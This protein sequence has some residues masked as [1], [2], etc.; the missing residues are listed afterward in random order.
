[1]I[2][3]EIINNVLDKMILSASGWRGVFSACGNEEGTSSEI[4]QAHRVICASAAL[5]F[6][7][8]LQN[9]SD[10]DTFPPL[11]LVA[12]DTRPT[13]KAIADAMIPALLNAGCNVRYAGIA[14]APEIMAWARSL[15]EESKKAGF[16]YISA[17]HNPIGHNG[18][19]FGL[20]DGGVLAAEEAGRLIKNFRS[21]LAEESNIEKIEKMFEKEFTQRRGDAKD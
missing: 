19:K 10:F 8:Y 11:V 4:S 5:I 3:E 6:A 9:L 14:A 13:G 2:S 16:I 7:E 17:S 21:F 1:M 12:S 20:T 18:L 15:A